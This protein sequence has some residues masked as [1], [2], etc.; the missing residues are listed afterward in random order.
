MD[1]F[2][3]RIVGFAVHEGDASGVDVCRMFNKI[4]AQKILPKYLS[5]DNDP[6]F[7]FHRWQANLCILQIEE[8]KSVP[9]IP[10]SHPFVERLIGSVR[11]ELL[12]QTLFWNV[13]DL[14]NKLGDFQK[15]YNE[16]RGH[17]GI[18]GVTPSQQ[19]EEKHSTTLDLNNYNWEKR[20]RALFQLPIAA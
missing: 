14:E 2:T 1:Q 13:S 15:Y 5:S 3:R 9:H 8:I 11:R 20:W 16:N 6:L 10:I 7:E 12:D 4:I 19:A 17:Y 18:S